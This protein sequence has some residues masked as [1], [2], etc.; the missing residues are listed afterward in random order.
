MFRNLSAPDICI[1]EE[2]VRS[3]KDYTSYVVY[4]CTNSAMSNIS[5]FNMRFQNKVNVCQCPQ[6]QVE[7]LIF[8]ME[9]SQTFQKK[10]KKKEKE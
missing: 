4:V 7:R 8:M 6:N 3:L 1:F 2:A 5:F 9:L 10:K